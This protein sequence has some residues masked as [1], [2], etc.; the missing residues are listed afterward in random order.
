MNRFLTG[1]FNPKGERPKFT[2]T[3]FCGYCEYTFEGSRTDGTCPRCADRNVIPIS[4]AFK[5]RISAP[6][7]FVVNGGQA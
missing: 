6:K 7:L 2:T 1:V 4:R 3:M 5:A